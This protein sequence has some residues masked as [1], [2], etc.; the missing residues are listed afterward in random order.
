[1]SLAVPETNK[2]SS[3]NRRVRSEPSLENNSDSRNAK[4]LKA[5]KQKTASCFNEQKHSG[6]PFDFEEIKRKFV[7][8]YS[9]AELVKDIG[10]IDSAGTPSFVPQVAHYLIDPTLSLVPTSPSGLSSDLENQQRFSKKNINTVTGMNTGHSF[11]TSRNPENGTDQEPLKGGK[12]SFRCMSG[13][14]QLSATRNMLWGGKGA[15]LREDSRRPIGGRLSTILRQLK[16]N[17]L[18]MD[19]ALP[20]ESLRPSR[21]T[22]E[23]R[24]VWRGF[25]KSAESIYEMIQATIVLEDMIKTAYLKKDWWYW[26]SPLVAAKICTISGLALRIYAF[27]AAIIY[28]ENLPGQ[29]PS[30]VCKTSRESPSDL[31]LETSMPPLSKDIKSD[32]PDLPRLR[33]GKAR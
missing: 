8:Q 30:E 31:N 10:L 29:E 28:E 14:D 25:V 21:A 6:C 15:I 23:K 11:S 17:L 22:S 7:T 32:F 9:L 33:S 12:V 2:D 24:R 13:V 4:T 5:E 26:S 1:M 16:I 3:I 19:A 20:E 27:D 18:D